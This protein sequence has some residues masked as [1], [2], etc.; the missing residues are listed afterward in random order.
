MLC[1]ALFC[2]VRSAVFRYL[3]TLFCAGLLPTLF[4]FIIYYL[5][6]FINF[7][8]CFAGRGF[9]FSEV[10]PFWRRGGGGSVGSARAVDD[11]EGI[12]DFGDIGDIGD[13]G[14][15][16][17]DI[18]VG[19]GDTAVGNSGIVLENCDL[20]VENS[21]EVVENSDSGVENSDVA[22]KNS[23]IS[24][25][26]GDTALFETPFV[27]D[28]IILLGVRSSVSNLGGGGRSFPAFF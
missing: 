23:D 21:D 26:N 2:S 8:L 6:L 19:N 4:F 20:S 22:V 27:P 15:G 9:M 28:G 13:S 5:R 11:S 25:E 16:H 12:T 18:V 3:L 24:I 14:G 17:G 10:F 1:S 7:T